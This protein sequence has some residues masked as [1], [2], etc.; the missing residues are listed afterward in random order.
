MP[1]AE[2]AVEYIRALERGVA[3]DDLAVFFHPDAVIIEMPNRL[4][5]SGRRSDLAA[6]MAAS[7]RGRAT[8]RRQTY[9]I[10]S[11]TSEL[12]RVALEIAWTGVLAV[13]FGTLAAGTEMRARTAVIIDFRG[14]KIA[15]QRHYDCYEP[16]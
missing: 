11:I 10:Q 5:P 2:Q 6:A 16:F 9:D 1:P 7:E 12:S 8:M 13:P 15:Q 3:G 4:N 14:E